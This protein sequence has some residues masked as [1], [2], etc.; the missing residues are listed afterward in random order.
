MNVASSS[1][2][3][4]SWRSIGLS[5]SL[6]IWY[7]SLR[8]PS[9]SEFCLQGDFFLITDFISLLMISL[10]KLSVYSWLSLADCVFLE[11][12]S[13]LLSCPICC[14]I[15]IHSSIL[16]LFVCFYHSFFSSSA[17]FFVVVVILLLISLTF[18]LGEPVR[19]FVSFV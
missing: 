12:Y 15:T 10:F 14:H 7:N 5:F 6:Y 1:V 4:N 13:F 16:W 2:F 11:T 17:T 3:W 18:L 19:R 9:G 8:K